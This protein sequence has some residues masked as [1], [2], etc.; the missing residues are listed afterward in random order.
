MCCVRF[1]R[2]AAFMDVYGQD[3]NII[4]KVQKNAIYK[5]KNTVCI[6]S[7]YSPLSS[8]KTTLKQQLKLFTYIGQRKG[9][10]VSC[11][12][13]QHHNAI[14]RDS[15][16]RLTRWKQLPYGTHMTVLYLPSFPPKTHYVPKSGNYCARTGNEKRTKTFKLMKT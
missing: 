16:M 1:C 8:Y 7:G 12:L 9:L 10:A 3:P 6:F 2:E 14:R 5:D 4:K 13:V 15:R 11:L